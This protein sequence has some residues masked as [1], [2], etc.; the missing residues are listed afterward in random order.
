MEFYQHLNKPLGLGFQDENL[1]D[2][3]QQKLIHE[4]KR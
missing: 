3:V 1:N 2:V 4:K